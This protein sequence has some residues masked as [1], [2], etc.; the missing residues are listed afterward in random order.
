MNLAFDI[1]VADAYRSKSQKARIITESW[2]GNNMYCPI[3]GSA[4]ILHFKANKPV[5][6]FFC[7]DCNSEYELKSSERKNR[8]FS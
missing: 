3:C 6:D 4:T 2:M 7:P 1:N 5:A 8:H